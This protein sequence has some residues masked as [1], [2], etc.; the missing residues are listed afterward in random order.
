MRT[1]RPTDLLDSRE[2]QKA[3][4]DSKARSERIIHPRGGPCL[5]AGPMDSFG[6][7]SQ[8]PLP[9]TSSEPPRWQAAERYADGM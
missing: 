5:C 4:D 3:G 1:R 8:P 2:P 7:R 9:L 6:Q